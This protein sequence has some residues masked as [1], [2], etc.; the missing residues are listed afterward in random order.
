[1]P[2]SIFF[3]LTEPEPGREDEYNDWYNNRHIPDVLTVPGF[4]AAQR[5]LLSNVQRSPAAAEG[6]LR[7]AAVYEIEGDVKQAVENLA[8]AAQDMFISDA[9]GPRRH[10]LVYEAIADRAVEADGEPA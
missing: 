6:A 3:V 2:S 1:M 5:F 8:E 10:A 9:M 7:Y 4:V